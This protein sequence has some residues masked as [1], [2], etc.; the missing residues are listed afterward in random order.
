MDAEREKLE[1]I[2][3]T[4][5]QIRYGEVVITIHDSEITQIEKSEKRRFK[6][7]PRPQE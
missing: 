3:S 4:V 2:I 1:E 5:K 7:Q 6:A